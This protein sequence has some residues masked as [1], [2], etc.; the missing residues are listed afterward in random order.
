[1]ADGQHA[2]QLSFGG[3]LR[4]MRAKLRDSRH[5]SKYNYHTDS[6]FNTLSI[7]LWSSINHAVYAKKEK[8]G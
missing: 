8:G 4:I 6:I 7:P 5:D 3:Y 2:L 1:M